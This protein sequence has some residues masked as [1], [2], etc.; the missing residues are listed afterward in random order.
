[1]LG[2]FFTV[3][4]GVA[5]TERGK[6]KMNQEALCEIGGVPVWTPGFKKDRERSKHKRVCSVCAHVWQGNT[7][8]MSQFYLLKEQSSNEHMHGAEEV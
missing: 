5:N 6:S 1:M 4:K 3:K 2:F 7:R 8:K